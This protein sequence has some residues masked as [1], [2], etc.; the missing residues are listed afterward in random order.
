MGRSPQLSRCVAAV[1]NLSQTEF[2]AS[3]GLQ[4]QMGG[5][6]QGPCS[7]PLGNQTAVLARCQT[8]RGREG[9]LVFCRALSALSGPPA[10]SPGGMSPE[11]WGA[12]QGQAAEARSHAQS[13][14]GFVF[15]V[16]DVMRKGSPGDHSRPL[17]PWGPETPRKI[18]SIWLAPLMDSGLG[19]QW[20]GAPLRLLPRERELQ[21]AK[22]FHRCQLLGSSRQPCESSL[23][24]IVI[25][26]LQVRKLRL[27]EKE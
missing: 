27:R 10:S 8:C 3:E 7:G 23:A 11:E 12:G 22:Y 2:K 14:A 25:P 1:H 24:G 13:L 26:I 20:A 19:L 16:T 21:F 6:H 9:E 5:S 18:S 4:N 17:Q 15:V